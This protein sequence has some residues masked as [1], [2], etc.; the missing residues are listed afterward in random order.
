MRYN[1]KLTNKFY[2]YF[3]SKLNL[4]QS[5]KGF[6][7]GDCPFCGGYFTFGANFEYGR[8]N[9]FKCDEGKTNLINVVK[10]IENID[11]YG[12]V[13]KLLNLQ[14]DFA[15][16][17]HAFNKPESVDKKS[18]ALPE[19]YHRVDMGDNIYA[20]AARN[21]LTKTRGF[22]LK[23]LINLSWGYCDSGPWA[24]YI[25]IPYYVMGKLVYFTSR[26]YM[27]SGPKFNNPKAEEYGIGKSQLI[28]NQDSL[29]LYEHNYIL[30]SATNAVTLGTNTIALGGKAISSY[31]TWLILKAPTKR[32]SIILDR[33]AMEE[34]YVMALKL[35]NYKKVKVVLV[36]DERDVNQLG[37][38]FT[39]E[40]SKHTKYRDYQ[41]L[42]K[43]YLAYAK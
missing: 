14:E 2:A 9:C 36:P 17:L 26:R 20:K 5:T 33:D 8:S 29:F 28:Y 25:I 16:T 13:L 37:R 42:Y 3:T 39:L 11:T 4:K 31:Q 21:Y 18:M 27:G 40:L 35:V 22:N 7:R 19:G 43:E 41:K 12:E 30:E 32:V 10:A 15:Y 24:G 6:Y 1:E 34:A 38:K 23:R